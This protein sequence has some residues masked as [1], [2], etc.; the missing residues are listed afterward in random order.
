[1][2]HENSYIFFLF[3]NESNYDY[4]GNYGSITEVTDR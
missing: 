2:L 4:Y 3:Q 1:M